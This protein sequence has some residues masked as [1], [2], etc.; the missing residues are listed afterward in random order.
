[1]LK[2]QGRLTS[3]DKSAHDGSG[4]SGDL[5]GDSVWLSNVRTPVTSSDG[6]DGEFGGDDGTSDGGSDF[7]GALDSETNV[8]K[9]DV[10]SARTPER[11]S[12]CTVRSFTHPSKS[13]TATAALNRVR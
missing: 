11:E 1:M 6:D 10:V 2:K 12:T 5:A 8:S 3:W 13:P 7:L 4:L 9:E